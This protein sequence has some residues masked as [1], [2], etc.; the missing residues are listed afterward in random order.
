MKKI[1]IYQNNLCQIG[2]VETF[3]YNWCW[4]MR[5]F[6]DI[7]VL[8][9]KGD[10]TRI[11]KMKQL[12][13]LVK[14]E[15]GKEYK[16][17]I[18]IRN[19]VWGEIPKG[20]KAKEHR[21]IEMRH[22]NYKFLLDK[23]KLYQQYHPMKEINEIV[24][25]GEFVSEMSRLVLKDNPTTIRNILLP[26]KKTKKV[27]HF[28]SCT[29]LDP[30]KGWNR[31]LKLCEMLR[32]ADIKFEWNVFTNAYNYKSPYEELHIWQQRYDIWDYLVDAD[33][34]VLLSD[35]EGMPYTV[36]ESLQYKIPCI[37]S[38]VGGCTEL[39]KDGV[40]GYVIPLNMEFDV[41]KL[42]KIPKCKE[43]ENH[44][45]EKWLDY[46]SIKYTD[47]DI[48]NAKVREVEEDMK[49]YLVEATEEYELHNVVD[50]ELGRKPKAGE[51]W[52][53]NK[54][55]LDV[56]LGENANNRVYV[57]LI[58]EIDTKDDKPKKTTKKK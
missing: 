12:A 37:V 1:I 29:R 20:I 5:N 17:D 31:M 50:S 41:N 19:G 56:L 58:K 39:I 52:E 7:T 10:T 23:G 51:Q 35:S 3:L 57:K 42:L 8:Y 38:D 43:Y 36:Q 15:E 14:Y 40:N 53:V 26:V 48:E 44:A 27:L 24:G 22:A 32:E 21:Y 6:A 54:E 11:A 25:C 16:C 28:I 49:K 55:R 33:Y 18:F 13:K 47:K 4:W 2:G 45:I 34:T 9:I 46:L 30:E